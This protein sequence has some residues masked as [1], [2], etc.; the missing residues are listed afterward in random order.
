MTRR[1]A[2]LAGGGV[3]AGA[4]AFGVYELRKRPASAPLGFELTEDERARAVGFL[5]VHPAVDAHA[6]PGRTFIRGATGLSL[7][8]RY[9]QAQGAFEARV[10]SD[11][12]QGGLAGSCFAAVA[13][14]QVLGLVGGWIGESRPFRAGEA[15]TSYQRQ[16]EHLKTLVDEGLVHL[17]SAPPDIEAARMVGKPAAIFSVEGGDFLEG[18]PERLADAYAKGVRF[19][20]LT[21]YRANEISRPMTA[22]GTDAGLSH[23][24]RGIVIQMNRLGMLIDLA[25]MP[26]AAAHEAIRI[27]RAPVMLSHTHVNSDQMQ[28]PR[29]IS[30]ELAKDVAASGG[31]IGAWP[32]GIG[33]SDL[34]G[35]VDRIF[36]LVDLIG[37]DHVCIGTD[38]DSNY[39]PVF[40]DYRMLPD[41]VGRI[42]TKGMGE[43]TAA[44]VLGGNLMRVWGQAKA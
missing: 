17:A 14:V 29:F 35:Y 28:H 38:M 42:L 3:I 40:N 27:S 12:K 9:F 31:L 22:A 34:A 5:K 32:A 41:M 1:R 8:L 19:L 20:T 2:L 16:V 36:G 39:R 21:H 7:A 10:V 23:A 33:I 26:E 30:R 11:M 43:A 4:A 37:E 18:S 24:G 15:L 25:H 44:K 6:H 13:D